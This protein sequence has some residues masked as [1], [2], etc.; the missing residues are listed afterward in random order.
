MVFGKVQFHELYQLLNTGGHRCQQVATQVQVAH[1]AEALQ[2]TGLDFQQVHVAQGEACDMAEIH[3]FRQP[4]QC[5]HPPAMDQQL[6]V[7]LGIPMLTLP[8]AAN[9]PR[10][11]GA[12]NSLRRA[13]R[14]SPPVP[15][16]VVQK[17]R[18]LVELKVTLPG[19]HPLMAG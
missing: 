18:L 6:I 14:R 5:P 2:E 9:H 17:A 1:P 4:W 12:T 7:A 3:G 8:S 19:R 11:P 13:G 16:R 10:H 15:Q